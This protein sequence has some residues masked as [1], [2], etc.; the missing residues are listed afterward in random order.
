MALD[1]DTATETDAV[2]VEEYAG[3]TVRLETHIVG[4]M[5]SPEIVEGEV[6]STGKTIRASDPHT[7]TSY[8]FDTAT[9]LTGDGESRDSRSYSLYTYESFQSIQRANHA[10]GPQAGCN[11]VS[12]PEDL[13][14][15]TH[16]VVGDEHADEDESDDAQPVA[17]GDRVRATG[18]TDAG[19]VLDARGTVEDVTDSKTVVALD[20]GRTVTHR[21]EVLI[22]R[23]DEGRVVFYR[24]GTLEAV[25]SD[26]DPDGELITTANRSTDQED[27][28]M[29]P[30]NTGKAILPDGGQTDSE[31]DE[32][33]PPELSEGDRLEVEYDPVN[34]EQTQTLTGTVGDVDRLTDGKTV[35]V[36]TAEVVPD[37]D[38]R[39]ERQ[40]YYTTEGDASRRVEFERTSDGDWKGHAVEGKNGARWNRI[41]E[42]LGIE[43]WSLTD[44][45]SSSDHDDAEPQT[46]GGEKEPMT[47]E[48]AGIIASMIPDVDADP[49]ETDETDLK[50]LVQ[51]NQDTQP[52]VAGPTPIT[53]GELETLYSGVAEAVDFSK[54]P[55]RDTGERSVEVVIGTVEYTATGEI[56]GC[57]IDDEYR[58]DESESE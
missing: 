41:S 1:C 15:P 6:S 9:I 12:D 11:G 58:A 39:V 4:V 17:E 40:D 34:G 25:S 36:V 20:D 47:S 18:E 55:D 33:T 50:L 48:S 31:A 32:K 57:E 37:D 10:P 45:D 16:E 35:H 53:P 7:D 3:E 29:A 46:D 28:Q 14:N 21:G 2:N 52:A 27:S 26:T 8:R 23:T 51:Q 42:T 19:G 44:G 54:A 43:S 56:V 30:N 49:E 24:N 22:H 13:P 38:I 5:N